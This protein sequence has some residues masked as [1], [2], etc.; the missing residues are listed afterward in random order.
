MSRYF[1]KAPSHASISL[2]KS[3]TQEIATTINSIFIFFILSGTNIFSQ[4][5]NDMESFQNLQ[6][7]NKTRENEEDKD[8]FSI[9]SERRISSE[10]QVEHKTS[11]RKTSCPAMM[12]KYLQIDT[13]LT[14]NQMTSLSELEQTHRDKALNFGLVNSENDRKRR[15]RK[16]S[17]EHQRKTPK[18]D[19]S[20]KY[21]KNDE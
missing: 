19:G 12:N 9:H 10:L 2:L 4:Q 7:K 16:K 18:S 11:I 20:K 5:F 15:E 21:V 17:F 13:A 6:E 1:C 3:S 8:S 14:D